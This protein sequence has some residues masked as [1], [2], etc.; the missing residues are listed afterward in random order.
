[1]V[2]NIADGGDSYKC[3]YYVTVIL[4]VIIV[5]RKRP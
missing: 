4:L 1:M 3:E 5:I 2:Y